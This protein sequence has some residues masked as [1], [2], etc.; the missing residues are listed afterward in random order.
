MH[1]FTSDLY[2]ATYSVLVLEEPLGTSKYTLSKRKG[3]IENPT[4]IVDQNFILTV[5]G[6]VR[7]RNKAIS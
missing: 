1:K 4:S 3:H 7:Y 2:Q 6:K 5:S